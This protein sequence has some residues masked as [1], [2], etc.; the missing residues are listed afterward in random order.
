MKNH[1][2]T[3]S[4]IKDTNKLIS[5]NDWRGCRIG[6]FFKF[7]S[8]LNYYVVSRIE[9]LFYLAEFEKI[10]DRK[11]KVNIDTGINLN[12]F[13]TVTISYK[14]W[15]IQTIIDIPNQGKGYK[16]GD[17]LSLQG[18]KP[19]SNLQDN[20]KEVAKISVDNTDESGAIL[21]ISLIN[22][23]KYYEIPEV[24]I[25]VNGVKGVKLKLRSNLNC[26]KIEQY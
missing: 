4:I 20:I 9:P 7:K 15:E 5:S 26:A 14:E 19:C 24:I 23:G 12:I 6:S 10:N 21:R 1:L 25:S 2:G 18:G 22:K 13:D 17:I 16:I 11:I 8:D 3:A